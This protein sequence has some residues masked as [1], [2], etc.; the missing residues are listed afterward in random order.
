M[1]SLISSMQTGQQISSFIRSLI[2]S[3]IRPP[4]DVNPSTTA[5][6]VRFSVR[7]SSSSIVESWEKEMF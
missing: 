6:N 4:D 1:F 2:R 3:L 7:F 5:D